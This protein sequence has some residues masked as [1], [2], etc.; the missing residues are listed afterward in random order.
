MNTAEQH[1]KHYI[2]TFTLASSETRGLESGS[3]CKAPEWCFSKKQECNWD[4]VPHPNLPYA[5]IQQM[6]SELVITMARNPQHSILRCTLHQKPALLTRH[7]QLIPLEVMVQ[8]STFATTSQH[9]Q[10]C[11]SW[12]MLNKLHLSHLVTA[13]SAKQPGCCRC[14]ACTVARCWLGIFALTIARP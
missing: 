10:Q 9:L 6:F 7:L 4:I 12:V 5:C 13:Q 11:C 3:Q 14:A 1:I 8:H 2:Y